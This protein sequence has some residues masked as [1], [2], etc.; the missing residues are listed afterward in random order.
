MTPEFSVEELGC[1]NNRYLAGRHI[2]TQGA[3]KINQGDQVAWLCHTHCFRNSASCPDFKTGEDFGNFNRSE[4][5]RCGAVFFPTLGLD[6]KPAEDFLV[7][8][9]SPT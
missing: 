5:V 4:V 9:Q 3:T 7:L 6:T 1:K 8:G 2:L